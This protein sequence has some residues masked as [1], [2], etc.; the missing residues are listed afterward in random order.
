MSS[1]RSGRF[2]RV[3]GE[4]GGNHIGA[5]PTELGG[6]FGVSVIPPAGR[7]RGQGRGS[8]T[9]GVNV[10]EEGRLYEAPL[11]PTVGRGHG[12]RRANVTEPSGVP[13]T[14]LIPTVGRGR[15]QRRGTGR[16]RGRGR[17]ATTTPVA[18]PSGHGSSNSN[19]MRAQGHGQGHTT[20][21][22]TRDELANEIARAIQA[23]LPNVIAQARD[24]I[25]NVNDDNMGGGEDEPEYSMPDPNPSIEQ[26]IGANNNHERRDCSYKTFM[27]CK[28]PVFD[29]EPDP[30]N[31]C[32]DED[33]VV[34]A[35]T[36]FKNEA[37]YWWGM[38]KEVRGHDVAK[39]M[40]WDEFTKIFK[41]KFCPRTAVKFI[42]KAR[43]AKL[44]VSTEE[45]G[46]ERYI[47]GLK[48]SIREF[49]EIQMPGTFQSAVDAAESRE[50]EKNRQGEDKTSGKRKSEVTSNEFKKGRTVS[51]ERKFEQDS[52]AKQCSKCNRYHD[53]E[54][55]MDQRTCYKCGKTGH[56]SPDCKVG[57]VCFGCGSPDHIRSNCPQ[58]RGNN[59]QGKIA[60]KDNR[61]A[62]K[63]TETYK[64]KVRSYNMTTMRV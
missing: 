40:T 19:R 21:V 41:E 26:P 10:T 56:L 15:G 52:E 48:T 47:W 35:V 28:P 11:V 17:G 43:F 54:C 55:T 36:M 16:G 6:V 38:V 13:E 14:P 1:R 63:K 20:N 2:T 44:Y 34:Y 58:N 33:R 22:V 18:A 39:R 4:E 30:I 31:K 29:G 37:I 9:V 23:A 59:N 24:A 53:G 49:V 60:D 27:T 62:D 46:V 3:T 8:N 32:A 45:M 12:Q 64:P 25:L 61:P 50:R 42:E 7:G 51:P 5:N 57:K